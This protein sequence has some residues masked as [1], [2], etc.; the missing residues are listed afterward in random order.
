MENVS[1]VT[2]DVQRV[3]IVLEALQS[4]KKHN[5]TADDAATLSTLLAWF[6]T[7]F[8]YIHSFI[9]VSFITGSFQFIVLQQVTCKVTRILKFVKSPHC[10]RNSHAIWGHTAEVT[11]PPWRRGV[12]VSG[13]RRMN[14]VYARWARLVPGWVTF[15][16][17][18]YHL[19]M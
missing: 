12:V 4:H 13:I 1:L 6:A 5:V 14:K 11:F 2:L 19:G 18:V 15:F 7:D 3:A 10:C 8:F 16:G 17:R 9:F